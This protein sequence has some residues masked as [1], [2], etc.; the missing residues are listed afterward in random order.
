MT[1][2]LSG[3]VSLSAGVFEYILTFITVTGKDD[4]SVNRAVKAIENALERV[5]KSEYIGYLILQN[6]TT[7]PR[8]VGS[9]GSGIER[10]KNE[11]VVQSLTVSKSDLPLIT[12]IGGCYEFTTDKSNDQN[13][14]K[15]CY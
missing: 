8:I 15:G 2:S 1:R 6:R 12:F 10:I 4:Q 13:R 9:K 7:F 3:R 11:S 14:F 5:K